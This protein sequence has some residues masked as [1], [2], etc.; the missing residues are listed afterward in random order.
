MF[1]ITPNPPASSQ[2][3]TVAP[4][5]ADR[6][7]S[8]YDLGPLRTRLPEPKNQEARWLLTLTRDRLMGVP[9]FS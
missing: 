4:H 7:L 5:I 1:K 3:E 9:R 8:H 6:A 2:A